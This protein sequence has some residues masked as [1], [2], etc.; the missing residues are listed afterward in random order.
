MPGAVC[1]HCGGLLRGHAGVGLPAFHLHTAVVTV[2][3]DIEADL[4]PNVPQ[5]HI[6]V[7]VYD[8]GFHLHLLP[9]N[10][11]A[12]GAALS[13]DSGGIGRGGDA[14]QQQAGQE[15]CRKTS[16]LH[17]VYL[18]KVL[19]GLMV[20]RKLAGVK[21]SALIFQSGFSVTLR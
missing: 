2:P 7:A 1:G 9:I 21:K 12:M 17:R 6:V 5:L 8:I 4:F 14:C 11:D 18:L 3:I 15:T 10:K 13:H 20:S 19:D 16:S